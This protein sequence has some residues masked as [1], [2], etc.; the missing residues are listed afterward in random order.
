MIAVDS[1]LLALAVNRW[2][3]EGYVHVLGARR[4]DRVRAEPFEAIELGVGA[5]FGDDD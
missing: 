2:A 1:G 5:L 4:G 3:P